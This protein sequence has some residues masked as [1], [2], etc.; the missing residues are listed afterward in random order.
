MVSDGFKVT[1]VYSEPAMVNISFDL[2][3]I[4]LTI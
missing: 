4:T 2:L 3:R 1:D